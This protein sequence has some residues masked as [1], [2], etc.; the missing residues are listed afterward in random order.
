MRK[1]PKGSTRLA[2]AIVGDVRAISGG[3][4]QWF[5][6]IH[7]LGLRHARERPEAVDSAIA[8]AIQKGWLAPNNGPELHSLCLAAEGD[9]TT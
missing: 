3:R 5:V 8:L 1:P 6:S 7:E 2:R 4:H 9:R